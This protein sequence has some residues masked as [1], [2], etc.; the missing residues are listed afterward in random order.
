MRVSVSVNP[1]NIAHSV[2]TFPSGFLLLL[3]W[4]ASRMYRSEFKPRKRVVVFRQCGRLMI[5]SSVKYDLRQ[6]IVLVPS[7]KHLE[8]FK[9]KHHRYYEGYTY[10]VI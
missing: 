4:V 6:F 5:R 1:E 7:F 3:L 10:R 2:P 8:I 9:S